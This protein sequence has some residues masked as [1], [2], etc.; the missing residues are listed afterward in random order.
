MLRVGRGLGPAFLASL[1][2]LACV[3]IHAQAAPPPALDNQVSQLDQTRQQC[4]STALAIQ[5]REKSIGA[6]DLAISVMER[7]ITAKNEEIAQS[8]QQQEVLLGALERLARAPPEA[9]AFAPE[10]PVDRLRSAIL[11]GAAVPALTAEAK[12]LGDQLKALSSVQS[13]IDASHKDIDAARAALA[14]GRDAL[15]QLVIRR[16]TLFTQMLHDDGKAAAA[17]QLGDQASDLFDLIKKADAASDQ[18]D[19]D[20]LVRLRVLYGAPAKGPAP[21]DPTRPKALRALDAPH[22]EMVWPVAGELVHR[23]GEADRYGRPSQGLALQAMPD[24]VVV[25]P[26]DGRVAYVGPFRNYG[27]IL[28]IRH[29]GGYHSLLAGLGHVDVTTGQW[30]LAGEPVGSLPDADNKG[31]SATF[32]LELRRD[33]RPVDP[34]SRLGTRD[35]KTEDTRVRE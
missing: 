22:A 24:G 30:L 29:A 5:Q 4:V 7:G 26:F 18:R 21:V 31:A 32:Y 35:Q 15:A 1:V 28:I 11:I 13:Q 2:A 25:A 19:K 17:T 33:G 3:V 34:Q 6:L 14:K 23:F 8:R 10:G 9:L 27:L 20:L 16:N 12:A